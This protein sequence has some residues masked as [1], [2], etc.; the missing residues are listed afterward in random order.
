MS[1]LA[2]AS[3]LVE[4]LDGET[5]SQGDLSGAGVLEAATA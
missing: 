3:E 4:Q 1:Q 2:R 5:A